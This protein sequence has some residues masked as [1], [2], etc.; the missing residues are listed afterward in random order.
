MNHKGFTL[1]VQFAREP[2]PTKDG[3]KEE[4]PGEVLFLNFFFQPNS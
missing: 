4:K 2:L 3:K 1:R